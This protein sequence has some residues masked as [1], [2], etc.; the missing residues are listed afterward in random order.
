M[1]LST[2][3]PSRKHHT[4]LGTPTRSIKIPT[5]NSIYYRQTQKM[6]RSR[7]NVAFKVNQNLLRASKPYS[8]I[9]VNDK[10]MGIYDKNVAPDVNQHLFLP[11]DL[12]FFITP[13]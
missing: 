11:K 6:P 1:P 9:P 10:K 7:R 5:Q 2:P 4:L 12:L 13:L 8:K 3:H